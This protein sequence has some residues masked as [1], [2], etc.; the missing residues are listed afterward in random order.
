MYCGIGTISLSIARHA[1]KVYGVEIVPQAIEDAKKNAL[2]NGFANAQFFCGKAEEVV[3]Q[4]YNNNRNDEESLGCHPD[5]VIVDPPRKGCDSILLDTIKQ[6]SPKRLVYVSCDPA[7]LARDIKLLSA[8]GFSLAK[9]CV[10][11]QFSHS[12]H[13]E[14]VALLLGT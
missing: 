3:P 11:D 9:V 1:K 14:T 10:V 5:V 13:V 7:T 8:H 2:K 6:M 12:N 4:F